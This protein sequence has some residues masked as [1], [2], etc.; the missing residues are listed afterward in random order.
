MPDFEQKDKSTCPL[1]LSQRVQ[2]CGTTDRQ[3][4]YWTCRDCALIWKPAESFITSAEE[5]A[6]YLQHQNTPLQNSSYA[7]YLRQLWEP[8]FTY[9]RQFHPERTPSILDFGSGPTSA[10]A[11]LL[12]PEG[13]HVT[14]YDLH[15]ANDPSVLAKKWDIVLCCE[16]WEHFRKPRHDINQVRSLLARHGMLAVR[17][18]WHSGPEHFRTWWYQHDPTH[19][20]FFNSRTLENIASAF[21]LEWVACAKDIA[22]YSDKAMA[23]ERHHRI[24]S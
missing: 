7:L 5:R 9:W 8:A 19:L 10:M 4:N 3:V 13:M 21:Q 6:R 1:C 11:D 12:R 18:A 2:L 17:T 16:V 14:S 15:F 22:I 24:S 20:H 23:A